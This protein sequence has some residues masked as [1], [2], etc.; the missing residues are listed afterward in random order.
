MRLLI[1]PLGCGQRAAGLL[2]AIVVAWHTLAGHPVAAQ[3]P[4]PT[5]PAT[6]GKT[7]PTFGKIERID[8]AFDELI[9]KDAKLEKLA[10]GFD[11]AEGPL[12]IKDG[13]YL[14]FSDIPPNRILKW[15][16]ED[17]IKSFLNQP[18]ISAARN[19]RGNPAPMA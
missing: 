14:L 2:I 18:A 11:W 5:V 9:A 1:G 12:W 13:S 19:G 15:S 17:A 10:E 8:P 7:Y 4:E 16:E 3:K 6:G